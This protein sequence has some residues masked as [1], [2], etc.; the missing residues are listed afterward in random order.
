KL[1]HQCLR[2]V[3]Q[4]LQAWQPEKTAS[5]FDGVNEAKDIIE[6]PGVVRVLFE[7]HKLD[8]DHVETCVRL[9]DKVPHQVVHEK[10][11]RRR[12]LSRPPL[13]VGSAASLSMK[14]LILVARYHH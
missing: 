11:L 12:A 3:S 2:R 10:R 4:R 8:A 14:R 7:T 5:A 9:G 6:N 13:S 1:A